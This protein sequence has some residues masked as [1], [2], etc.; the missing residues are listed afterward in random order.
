[1]PR[2]RLSL[3]FLV[4]ALFSP[5]W[6]D[7]QVTTPQPILLSVSPA[8]AQS[9]SKVELGITGTDLDGAAR[10]H[11]S[12]PGVICESKLNDKQQPVPNKFMVSF[13]D[14]IA[15]TRCDV[16]VVARYGISNPRGFFI[17]PWPVVS[18]PSSATNKDTPFVAELDTVL[19]GNSMKQAAAFIRF[20]A[21]KD[22]RVIA[23]CRPHMFDSRMEVSMSLRDAGGTKLAR[24]RSEGLLDFT[25]PSDGEFTLDLHDLM[26]RGDVEFPYVLTLT[27]KPVI[28]YVF[29]GKDQW[30]LYGRNLPR[31]GSIPSFGEVTMQRAAV[32]PEDAKRMLA[33]NP[34]E[35][36][37]FG[38]E[39]DAPSAAPPVVSLTAPARYTGWFAPNGRAREFTFEAKKG[40]VR[41]LEVKC[42]SKDVVADPI[43]IVEKDGSFIAE[44][45]DRTAI[46]TRAEFEQGNLD[47]TYRFEAK[48]DGIYR[49]KLRNLFSRDAQEPFELSVR[50]AAAEYE[51]V[52][53]PLGPPK[54]KT[55]TTVEI[56]GAPLWRGGVAVF[57]VFALRQGG[58]ND[59]IE[60]AAEGLPETVKFLGG[61]IGEGQG[62]GYAS[63]Y[64]EE[65][66]GDWAGA[67][68]LRG[69]DGNAACGATP[70]FKV[71][72]TA[73]ESVLTRL[74]EEV[75]LAVTAAD[76]PTTIEPVDSVTEGDANAKLSIPLKV[77]RRCDFTDVIAL[78]SVGVEGM[79]ATI[80]AKA[81]E[82]RLVVDVAKLKL[83]VGDHSV[84]LQGV[85][86]FKHQ[87]GD[88]AKAAVKELAFLV[89]SK[90]IIIRVKPVEK[91][92]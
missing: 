84:I 5:S 43:L 32:P 22:Q 17:T 29:A 65:S 60:L 70:L 25:A 55:A 74:T 52:A 16:R 67:L 85:V 44:A 81:N 39:G 58:C 31:G 34:V 21:R 24:S 42:S 63:F 28:Q 49:V 48:E 82:G 89:H 12:V 75:V 88:D 53:L 11:F 59:A 87:R 19:V 71:A 1:M 15:A 51:L 8:A 26:F 91:K 69:K 64:A 46:A 2:L 73:K 40:D 6:L 3:S 80:A 33:T 13:P 76:A 38:A 66:A 77:T 37:R 78:T 79:T 36:I 57:K 90:P 61:T 10:L 86:K 41:W 4:V 50:P 18:V 83:P 92:A 14:G 35:A 23:A 68:K 20:T 9:G 30:T 72:S 7:A 45:N 47:P 62:V 56:I 27:T 54:P